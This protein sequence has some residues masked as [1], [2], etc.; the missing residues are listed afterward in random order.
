MANFYAIKSCVQGTLHDVSA[1]D[2]TNDIAIDFCNTFSQ[3]RSSDSLEARADGVAAITIESNVTLTFTLGMEVLSKEVLALVLGGEIKENK[4]VVSKDAPSKV[5]S[6]TG[7]FTMIGDDGTKKIQKMT[8]GK[9]TPVANSTVDFSA[10]DLSTFEL[11]FSCAP[12]ESGNFY[13]VED[14]L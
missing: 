2:T 14:Q 10:I 4:I 8:I 3:E 13:T 9:C 1:L 11:Q 5:F 12:D 7:V 6:Y